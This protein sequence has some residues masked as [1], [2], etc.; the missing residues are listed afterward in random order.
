M[1]P[2]TTTLRCL[3]LSLIVATVA[4]VSM[5]QYAR[6]TTRAATKTDLV[7]YCTGNACCMFMV[8]GLGALYFC[9]NDVSTGVFAL[10]MAATIVYGAVMGPY[11][12]R[13][14]RFWKNT[15]VEASVAADASA[16]QSAPR[17][18]KKRSR[19]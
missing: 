18:A 1:M 14:M 11:C 3:I 17:A 12:V 9:K 7:F 15:P 6:R 13:Q 8:A 5:I 10:V 2:E 19:R 16:T 4:V